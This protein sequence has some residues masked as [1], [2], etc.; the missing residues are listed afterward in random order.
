VGVITGLLSGVGFAA[1][2]LMGKYSAQRQINPWTTLMYSFF[3]AGLFLAAFN[4]FSGWLPV[5]VASTDFFWLG[6]DW[7]AWL[8]LVALAWLPTIGG[9]GLYTVSLG[10]L[11]VSVANL[12]ATLEPA[13]TAVWA[14]LLLGER[15]A[16]LQLFGSA[17]IVTGVLLLRV[18]GKEAAPA[19][20]TASNLT[21]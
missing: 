13:L 9:Y 4:F 6:D 16:P 1:Y 15:M 14:Y 8:V 17:M 2:S 11:P 3:F 18:N 5:G 20:E 12:I 21:N 7:I 10:Y 19:A